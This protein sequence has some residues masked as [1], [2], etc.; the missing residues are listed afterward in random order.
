M[1]FLSKVLQFFLVCFLKQVNVYNL[2]DIKNHKTSLFVRY[3]SIIENYH[4]KV[5]HFSKVEGRG[6]FLI[7]EGVTSPTVNFS[8]GR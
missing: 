8:Y 6:K 1:T 3:R 5:F 2:T 7:A 4:R